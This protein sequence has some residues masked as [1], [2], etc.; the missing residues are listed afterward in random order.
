[1]A[2]VTISSHHV[3]EIRFAIK[4]LVLRL[5]CVSSKF[6]FFFFLLKLSAVCTFWIVL[7]C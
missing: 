6:D 4:R 5:Y 3:P 7:I 1:M 2:S